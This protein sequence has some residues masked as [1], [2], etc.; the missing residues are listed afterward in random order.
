MSFLKFVGK[1]KKSETNLKSI[2]LDNKTKESSNIVE[3][4][5]QF[6]SGSQIN[7]QLV[8]QNSCYFN[9]IINGNIEIHNKLVLGEN[10]EVVGDVYAKNLLIKGKVKGNII[11][12]NKIILSSSSRITS[13]SLYTNLIEVE[14]GAVLNVSNLVMQAAEKNALLFPK[15]PVFAVSETPSYIT[16]S[17]PLNTK[18]SPEINSSNDDDNTFF[19]KIF[20]NQ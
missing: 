4:V 2:S 5:N 7:G 1:G 9:G 15:L 12:E 16:T 17:K 18:I 19:F 10:S 20:Q 6:Q 8:S 3:R 11:V 14:N 13:N